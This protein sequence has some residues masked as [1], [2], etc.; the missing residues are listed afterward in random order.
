M[1]KVKNPQSNGTYWYGNNASERP[2]SG[3]TFVLVEN[4]DA[5]LERV[6]VSYGATAF[7][8]SAIQTLY[9]CNNDAFNNIVR[10]LQGYSYTLNWIPVYGA[11]TPRWLENV[12]E[13]WF[14]LIGYTPKPPSTKMQEGFMEACK[15]LSGLPEKTISVVMRKYA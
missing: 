2:Y 10:T 11:D 14:K 3:H 15:M 13:R 5:L 12:E 6:F 9:V 8:I 7:S 4:K 1:T